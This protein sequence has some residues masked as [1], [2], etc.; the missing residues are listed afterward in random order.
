[1]Y[2]KLD[3]NK[4]S[5]HPKTWRN[6]HIY[7]N[8]MILC[9]GGTGAGKSNALLNYIHRSSGEFFQIIICSFSTTDEPLYNML[10]EKEPNI[11]LINN[12]DDVPELKDFDNVFISVAGFSSSRDL[13]QVS[14]RCR[15]LKSNQIKV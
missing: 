15:N 6:H 4:K 9:I 1:L 8:S 12:I 7:N 3:N 2:K 14:Y 5:I 13:I 10:H 11:H